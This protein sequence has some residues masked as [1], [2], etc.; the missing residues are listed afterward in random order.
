MISVRQLDNP[1]PTLDILELESWIVT[2][3]L[4]LSI[5]PV[6]EQLGFCEVHFMLAL[7]ALSM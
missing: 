5:Q 7:K 2:L 6:H 1:T 3:D 4:H